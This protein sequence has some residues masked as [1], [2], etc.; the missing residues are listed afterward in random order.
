ML[1]EWLLHKHLKRLEK[2]RAE[3]RRN[4]DFILAY[5]QIARSKGT[6]ALSSPPGL[7][8][9]FTAGCVTEVA[10]DKVTLPWHML[11][12]ILIWV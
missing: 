4:T 2:Q 7:A 5:Q 6:Q 1:A 9:C 11:R 10:R 3:Y 12:L 8:I